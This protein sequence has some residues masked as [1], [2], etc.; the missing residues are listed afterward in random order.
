[1]D[2]EMIPRHTRQ[3]EVVYQAS[4]QATDQPTD[5]Q[6]NQPMIDLAKS[7]ITEISEMW[8]S[9]ALPAWKQEWIVSGEPPYELKE[10][11]PARRRGHRVGTAPCC[12]QWLVEAQRQ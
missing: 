11:D 8:I 10:A 7:W 4:K 12:C 2:D 3:Y 9:P 5:Q 1:M 6:T